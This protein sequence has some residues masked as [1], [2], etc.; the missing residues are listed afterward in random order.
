MIAEKEV[1]FEKLAGA[2]RRPI[3]DV[4]PLLTRLLFGHRTLATRGVLGV[5]IFRAVPLSL[6]TEAERRLQ[7][8]RLGAFPLLAQPFLVPL[9]ESKLALAGLPA[10]YGGRAFFCPPK[11]ARLR[12]LGDYVGGVALRP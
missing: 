2:R 9:Q 10:Q 6:L 8:L 3:H 12:L 5:P 7:T 4:L 11:D 1:G